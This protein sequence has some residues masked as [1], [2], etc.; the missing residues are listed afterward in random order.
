M[1]IAG[2]SASSPATAQMFDVQ[3]GDRIV[4]TRPPASAHGVRPV[5]QGDRLVYEYDARGGAGP[6]RIVVDPQPVVREIRRVQRKARSHKS[7]KA[8]VAARTTPET[9]DLGASALTPPMPAPRPETISRKAKD[10]AGVSRV[11]EKSTGRQRTGGARKV[12]II[13]LYK[14]PPVQ[15]GPITQ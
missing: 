7:R 8:V 14:I 3:P 10:P 12:R 11:S 1:A 6:Q 5:E 13:P 2:L 9:E 4:Y 15:G